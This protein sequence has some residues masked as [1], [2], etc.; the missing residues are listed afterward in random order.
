[1]RSYS[2][3][4]VSSS[5]ITRFLKSLAG[6]RVTG[7]ERLLI[8]GLTL[9]LGTWLFREEPQGSCFRKWD[10]QQGIHSRSLFAEEGKGKVGWA[11]ISAWGLLSW[12]WSHFMA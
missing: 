1:M 9:G 12:P 3:F 4:W 6:D 5:E 8:G 2:K 11:V 10:G 7:K